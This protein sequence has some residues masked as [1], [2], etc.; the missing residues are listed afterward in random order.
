MT[1]VVVRVIDLHLMR[2]IEGEPR[3]LL[4]QRSPGQLYEGIWQGVT[5]KIQPGE[6]AWE[7]ALRELR[8]ETGLR[9]L[10][11]W[12]VDHVNFYYEAATDQLNG[13]PVFG[14]ELA[15]GEVV[16]SPEHQA[17]RWCS[18]EEAAELLLWD[19]QREGLRVFH[20]MLTRYPDKLRWME[21]AIP[22]WEID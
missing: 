7:A 10:K 20:E 9:P 11:M 22:P 2:W 18:V 13:I 3:Y 21:I 12:T 15:P 5:G 8:E 19:Q 6:K 1:D 17:H 14:V 16:L 4:L